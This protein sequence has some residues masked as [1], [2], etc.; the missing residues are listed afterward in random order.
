MLK[1][2]GR[3]SLLGVALVSLVFLKVSFLRSSQTP[4]GAPVPQAMDLMREF[5]GIQALMGTD[6]TLPD[7]T[8]VHNFASKQ[9]MLGPVEPGLAWKVQSDQAKANTPY[10]AF[11][12]SLV[13][14]DRN[15]EIIAGWITDIDIKKDGYVIV[16]SQKLDPANP[17][18]LREVVITDETGVI[19]RS[20]VLGQTQPAA[21]DL[22]AS[23]DF[24][25]AQ[26]WDLYAN[27]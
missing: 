26:P 2:W 14:N 27:N 19:C 16:N 12:R 4:S 22:H 24:P 10:G 3:R 18:K 21:A 13:P 7:G 23:R 9:A 25:G 5:N 6:S 1:E 8:V 11:L 17:N 20:R 15:G